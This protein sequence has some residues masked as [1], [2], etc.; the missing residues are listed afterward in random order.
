MVCMYDGDYLLR[1]GSLY[2]IP[3]DVFFSYVIVGPGVLPERINKSSPIIPAKAE[4]QNHAACEISF[5]CKHISESDKSYGCRF[6]CVKD[7]LA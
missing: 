4:F 5:G 7:A 2:L 6:P 1:A 3:Q